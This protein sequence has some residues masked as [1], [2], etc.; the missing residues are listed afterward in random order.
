MATGAGIVATLETMG[1]ISV[2]RGSNSRVVTITATGKRTAGKVKKTILPQRQAS[3]VWPNN[4]DILME[5]VANGL[6]FEQVAVLC[7]TSP[8][9]AAS[10]FDALAAAMGTQAA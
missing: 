7:H 3:K 4:D 2:E 5:G 10:R 1:M 9:D 8:E 6:D